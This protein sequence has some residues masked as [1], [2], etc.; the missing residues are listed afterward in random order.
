MIIFQGVM[1]VYDITNEKSFQNIGSWIKHIEEVKQITL[2][3]VSITS[4]DGNMI[5]LNL[6]ECQSLWVT[7]YIGI[8]ELSL[9]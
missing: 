9:N 8:L 7:V 4:L 2:F 1:L 6:E 5:I 3:S